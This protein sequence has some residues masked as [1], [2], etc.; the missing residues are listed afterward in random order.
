M[1]RGIAFL[2]GVF[3]VVTA[4]ADMTSVI[5][6]NL[7][8]VAAAQALRSAR[9]GA[10]ARGAAQDPTATRSTRVPAPPSATLARAVTR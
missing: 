4:I 3:V 5:P 10:C 8:G 6:F 2:L 1:I 7:T 9:E